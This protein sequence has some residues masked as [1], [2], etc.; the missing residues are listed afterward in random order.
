MPKINLLSDLHNEGC[1]FKTP[2]QEADIIILAGDIGSYDNGIHWARET[3]P[4]KEIIYVPG[5]HEFYGREFTDTMK[6]M[7]K[8]AKANRVHFLYNKSIVLD[9]IAFHGTTLWT[10]FCLDGA[11]FSTAAKFAA[12]AYIRDFHVIMK[13]KPGSLKLWTPN[14]AASENTKARKFL[15]N[16]LET[17]TKPNVVIT[18]FLPSFR[19]VSS[20]FWNSPVNSYFA[21]NMEPLISWYQPM[22]WLH[23][24]THDSMDYKLGDT[25]VLCNPRGYA[26]RKAEGG[27]EMENSQFNPNMIIDI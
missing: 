5:N 6:S 18:H 17:S 11:Q 23:G 16:A 21:C 7:R 26:N 22:Y 14:N 3:W 13:G 15:Y 27:I 20:K 12:K 10:D 24:H 9:G 1:L 25:H 8:A 4:D 2:N 19:S